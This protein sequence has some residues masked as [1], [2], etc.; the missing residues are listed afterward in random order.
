MT[1]IEGFYRAFNI[2]KDVALNS[3]SGEG[4]SNS[5]PRLSWNGATNNKMPSTRF[6]EDGSYFRLKNVQLGYTFGKEALSKLNISNIRVY[7]KC[8]QPFY[9]HK[10]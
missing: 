2:T 3:W 8:N 1:D 10:I 7:S 9:D 6:L 4:T 5:L